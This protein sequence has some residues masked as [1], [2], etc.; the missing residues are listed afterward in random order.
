[1][2]KSVSTG[3]GVSNIETGSSMEQIRMF[4]GVHIGAGFIKEKNDEAYREL[5]SRAL[6]IG[7]SV[8]KRDGGTGTAH[9]AVAATV[10]VFEES[11][12]VNCGRG[13]NLNIDGEVECDASIMYT[14]VPSAPGSPSGKSNKSRRSNRNERKR[15]F[16][17]TGAVKGISSPITLCLKVAQAAENGL[18]SHGR[19][20]PR[21]LV[22]KG[23]TEWARNNGCGNLLTNPESMVSVPA[24]EKWKRF[25]RL[26]QE[27]DQPGIQIDTNKKRKVSG[28]LSPSE[29][30]KKKGEL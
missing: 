9:E 26:L 4:L 5:L 14:T 13:S 2:S 21:V 7:M 15:H 11:G 20:P 10:R 3:T 17:S 1:M 12:R 30:M 23:A 18:L 24:F 25:K 6:G 16:A 29:A 27:T 19:V 22:C 8:L 28:F